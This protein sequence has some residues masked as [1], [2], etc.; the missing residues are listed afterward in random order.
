M[1]TG[2]QLTVGRGVISELV[3][4]AAFEVPGVARVGRGGA[5]WRRL[6]AGPAVSVQL[7]NDRVLV[8]LWI[9]ARPGQALGPLTSQVR[10][11]VRATVER[12]LGLDLGAVTVVVDGVG[13]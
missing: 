3:R 10:A 4:L 12:L 8:R 11:A 7:R 6:L 1:V 9:V 5:T 13:G 2:P